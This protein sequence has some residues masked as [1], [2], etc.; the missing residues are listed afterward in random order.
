[1]PVGMG[2]EKGNWKAIKGAPPIGPTT[3][4]QALERNWS[5]TCAHLPLDVHLSALRKH[6]VRRQPLPQEFNR[7]RRQLHATELGRRFHARGGVDRVAEEAEAGQE[8]A[9]DAASDGTAVDADA[10]LQ[11]HVAFVEALHVVAERGL[12]FMHRGH[13][14]KGEAGQDHGVAWDR[15]VGH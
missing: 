4:G 14:L 3:C 1:M 5:G 13:E 10:H 11:M 15:N 8:L 6:Q 9:Y 2:Q 12:H 7:R